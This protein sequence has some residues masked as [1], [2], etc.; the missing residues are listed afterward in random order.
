MRR[1]P[2]F[3]ETGAPYPSE[4]RRASMRHQARLHEART[5]VMK[6]HP[7]S[8][9]FLSPGHE[10]AWVHVFRLMDTPTRL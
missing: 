2:R 10:R 1:E 4:R 3:H 8:M 9:T 6:L 7:G 5:A